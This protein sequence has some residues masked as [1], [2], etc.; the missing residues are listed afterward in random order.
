[1]ALENLDRWA[2][3]G[4]KGPN[5]YDWAVAGIPFLSAA[6]TDYPY[7]RESLDSNKQ[8]IDTAKEVGE[9]ALGNWWY[10]SQSSFDLGA[11]AFYTDTARDENIS[12]RF[13]DSHGIDALEEIGQV[14]L[15]NQMRETY[16]TT[17]TV[18]RLVN[19]LVEGVSGVLYYEGDTLS[20][21]DT[22]GNEGTIDYGGA[23]EDWVKEEILDID[24]DG[25]RYFVLT[26]TSIYAGALPAGDG[27]KVIEIN[28]ED[29]GTFVPADSGIIR[30]IKER[31][32]IGVTKGDRSEL[33]QCAV[34]KIGETKVFKPT[35]VQGVDATDTAPK[36]IRYTFDTDTW[37]VGVAILKVEGSKHPQY[38][39]D[40]TKYISNV[41]GTNKTKFRV[42]SATL[43]AKIELNGEQVYPTDTT[44]EVKVYTQFANQPIQ[45]YKSSA[46]YWQW[47]AVAD[48]PNGIYCSGYS[49]EKTAIL[50]STISKEESNDIPE[51][52]PPYV[53]S[54]LP[55]GEVIH[56]MI[57]YLSVYLIIGTNRGVRVAIIDSRGG[58]IMG[59]LSIK[60][61]SP[62][63]S[64]AASGDFVY[65]GG[66]KSKSFAGNDR[67]AIYKL[68][69]SK[70]IQENSLV[71][72]YQKFL[73]IGDQ[74]YSDSR[75][76]TSIIKINSIDKVCFSVAGLGIYTE[77]SIKV[78]KGWIETGKIRLDTAEDKIFQYLRVSNLPVDGYISVWWRDET[79]A[80]SS[81]YINR[82]YGDD[83]SGDAIANTL[84][85]P[86]GIRGVDMEGTTP[87][88]GE[89]SS[90]PYISYRF[91]LERG[92]TNTNTP[93]L[94]SYQVK[95]N[96]ANIKQTLVRLPLVLMNRETPVKGLTIERPV[97]DRLRVLEKAEQD[98]KVVLFQDF[99]TGEERLVIIEKLQFIS[100]HIPESRKAADRGGILLITLRTV[101]PVNTTGSLI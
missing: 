30:F 1:M 73:F 100:N 17:G 14:T 86:D 12:R 76:V 11:N 33:Y 5:N 28:R 51:L 2:N 97:F 74:T 19:F 47:S 7:L 66:A 54:E 20:Y 38:N 29:N 35:A 6:S 34:A 52:Q 70:P 71:F 42:P 68:N 31:L 43:P 59:P 101:D 83:Y 94:L 50:F 53:V 84:T 81:T 16:V 92:E 32:V 10:R 93:V 58:L 8:Q 45:I 99:G 77:D 9:Q 40:T 56:S 69:L 13:Y 49:G 87:V 63:K 82:W 65:A 15:Q 96:P 75:E 27:Y 44:A 60:S 3:D 88:A 95:A 39:F 90:H 24:S 25:T 37:K 80:L 23:D 62:V 79:N 85:D 67:V 22:A 26:P 4:S 91:V 64:L 18:P 78:D 89:I 46:S 72:A 55:S 57:S 98:G 21:F 36:G 41:G 61:D 48:G